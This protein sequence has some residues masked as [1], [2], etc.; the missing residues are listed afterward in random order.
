MKH[1]LSRKLSPILLLLFATV[2][3]GNGC[4]SREHIRPEYGQ[5]TREFYARQQ[6]YKEAEKE[7]Q[8]GLDSEEASMVHGNY[9]KNMGG[10]SKASS[11]PG[12]KVL[13]IEENG[14]HDKR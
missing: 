2:V 5:H 6:V 3:W 4:A 7:A 14:R 10:G 8:T 1:T 13:L 12:S 11:D 9:R